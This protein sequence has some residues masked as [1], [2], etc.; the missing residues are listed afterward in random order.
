MT[1]DR[2][3]SAVDRLTDAVK[4]QG[5]SPTEIAAALRSAETAA[6]SLSRLAGAAEG[7]LALERDRALEPDERD[8]EGETSPGEPESPRETEFLHPVI[9]AASDAFL[10]RFGPAGSWQGTPQATWA[11][12]MKAAQSGA[13]V[14]VKAEP[15]AA[16]PDGDILDPVKPP[17]CTAPLVLEATDP[18]RIRLTCVGDVPGSHVYTFADGEVALIDLRRA[19]EVHRRECQRGRA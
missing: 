6:T 7:F 11:E 8:V 1:T 9:K 5:F 15:A 2:I 13:G 14:R 19:V 17:Q 10:A 18:G 4:R 12:A 3:A 16:E